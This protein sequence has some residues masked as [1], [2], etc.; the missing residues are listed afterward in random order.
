M[1]IAVIGSSAA[2]NSALE[3][4]RAIDQKSP[5]VLISREKHPPYSRVLL[6][7]FL[8]GKIECDQLFY[9]PA[10][11]F[12]RLKVK[13]RLGR[14]VVKIDLP[15][16][17]LS[18]D[19]GEQIPFDKL[20]IASGS[21]PVKP[22]I[23]GIRDEEIGHLWTIEDAV[24]V[25]P[26]LQENKHLTIIGGGNIALM[27]AWVA[28]QRKMKVTVI[29][30]LPQVLP[31]ILD[32]TAAERLEAEIRR[33]GTRVLT[34]T[35]IK[36][37]E[38]QPQGHY[39]VFPADQE[40]LRADRIIIAAGVRPNTG[41]VDP[42]RIETD[43]GILVND[44]METSVSDIYAAGDVAQGPL[45]FGG[46]CGVQALWTTA[47]EH[48]RIA[49][50]NM[51]GRKMS[52]PGSLGGSVSEFFHMTVASLGLCRE[53]PDVI[54]RESIDSKRGFYGKFFWRKD[55][56]VGGWM[57]GSPEDVSAFGILR[58]RILKTLGRPEG[59]RAVPS[60]FALGGDF[61]SDLYY[62]FLAKIPERAVPPK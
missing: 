45:A 52:Y 8:Q 31:Q 60:R 46:P 15:L 38:K 3:A 48:G 16:K 23:P 20:L 56:P 50:A 37:I 4:F 7:Y 53:T 62:N 22:P 51:A 25:D 61:A 18:L 6:P 43:I 14:S 24:R 9:R 26:Q 5:V 33:T 41:F 29:E 10:D 49:G 34:G 47:V 17:S 13:T 54:G 58:A 28:F 36:K 57:L 19:N 1:N 27:L 59:E 21:S 12:D 32:R 42:D 30:W 11:F 35:A 40:P 2:A 55:G 44:R 39:L